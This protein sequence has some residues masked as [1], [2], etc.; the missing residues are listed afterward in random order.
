MRTGHADVHP[1]SSQT[2]QP[3]VICQSNDVVEPR[4]HIRPIAT[5]SVATS[6]SRQTPRL[7]L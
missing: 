6:G 2:R 1:R 7:E 5:L 3:E 4:S